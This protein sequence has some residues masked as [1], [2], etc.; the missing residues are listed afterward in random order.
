MSRADTFKGYG[1]EQGYDFLREA[2]VESEYKS[3]GADI[4]ADEIFISDGSKCD[5]GNILEIFGPHNIIAMQDPVYPVYVDTSVMAG[6]TG[7]YTNK[8]AIMTDL[9]YMPCTAEN[10]FYP[11]NSLKKELILY[12][13]AIRTI[14]TGTT[15]SKQELKKWVDYA[16]QEQISHSLRCCL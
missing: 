16:L 8:A 14:P 2:I 4:H 15:A 13:F 11:G 5:T 12:F 7:M 1:P 3:R 10:G 6:R 9:V